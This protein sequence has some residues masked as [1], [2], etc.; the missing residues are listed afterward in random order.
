MARSPDPEPENGVRIA[1]VSF[2]GTRGQSTTMIAATS[3][4]PKF[5]QRP[6]A[7]S[8][9]ANQSSANGLSHVIVDASKR[10]AACTIDCDQ[11]RFY[12]TRR[13]E[14]QRLFIARDS[15]QNARKFYNLFS[16]CGKST[17][18]VTPDCVSWDGRTDQ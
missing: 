6:L 11:C 4:S 15:L 16:D 9:V 3:Y 17:R 12:R 8:E 13:W 10:A 5:A 7:G 18:Y 2:E 14:K 1:R